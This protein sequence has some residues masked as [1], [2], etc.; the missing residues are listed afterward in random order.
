MIF[1]GLSHVYFVLQNNI[2]EYSRLNC[3]IGAR[4]I[5]TA[6]V[7]KPFQSVFQSPVPQA[8]AVF[9]SGPG[10]SSAGFTTL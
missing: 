8:P 5:F 9:G 10:R 4:K 7:L 1:H 2:N 3:E 6:P